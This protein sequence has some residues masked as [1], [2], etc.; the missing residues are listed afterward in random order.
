MRKKWNLDLLKSDIPK[1]RKNKMKRNEKMSILADLLK[2]GNNRF[3]V[4]ELIT[5]TGSPRVA[6][7]CIWLSRHDAGMKL[8]A[9]RD[10]GH[11][12][13]AYI[14]LNPNPVE[15][16]VIVKPEPVKPEPVKPISQRFQ[17]VMR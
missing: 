13:I 14:Q 2:K 4:D 17:D 6:R 7:S 8:E 11:K 12:V 1:M 15:T 3:T 10:E 5:A 16:E 9:V